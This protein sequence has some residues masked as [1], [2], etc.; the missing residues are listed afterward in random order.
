MDTSFV[1]WEG[2]AYP[3]NTLC[4]FSLKVSII[5]HINGT[6]YLVS[7]Y[8]MIRVQM[9]NSLFSHILTL[10]CTEQLFGARYIENHKKQCSG[11]YTQQQ[12]IQQEKCVDL[13]LNEDRYLDLRGTLQRKETHLITSVVSSMYLHSTPQSLHHQV[14]L[15]STWVELLV[16]TYMHCPISFN[17]QINALHISAA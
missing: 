7:L 15:N 4:T 12:A 2:R 11:W 1:F 9:K 13:N 5:N 17:L 16:K 3:G 6:K 10:Y 8:D 14:G